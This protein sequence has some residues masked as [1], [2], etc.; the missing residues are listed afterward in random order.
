MLYYIIRKEEEFKMK[1]VS[2]YIL[3]DLVAETINIID[4][5]YESLSFVYIGFKEL[6]IGWIK[7]AW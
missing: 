3:I 2:K 6:R 4:K 1:V 7:L 5:K